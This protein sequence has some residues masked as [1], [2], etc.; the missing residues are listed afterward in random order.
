MTRH[1][2]YRTA[3]YPAMPGREQWQSEP[4]HKHYHCHCQCR[5]HRLRL[6]VLDIVSV[7]VLV[8]AVVKEPL[9]TRP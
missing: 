4:W 8:L 5:C 9:Q 7:L 2:P 6:L 3:M 1:L